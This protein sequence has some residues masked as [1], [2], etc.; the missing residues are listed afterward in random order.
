MPVPI[1][2]AE[3]FKLKWPDLK[4]K[5]SDYDWG[6]V[7][8]KLFPKTVTLIHPVDGATYKFDLNLSNKADI[9]YAF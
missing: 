8:N 1:A 7:E 3:Q 9:I 6:F 2:N 5:I 4:L